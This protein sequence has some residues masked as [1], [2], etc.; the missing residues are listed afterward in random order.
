MDPNR[1][2]ALPA[3]LGEHLGYEKHA[4]EKSAIQGQA[5]TFECNFLFDH[6]LYSYSKLRLLLNGCNNG[7]KTC[8][9]MFNLRRY[10]AHSQICFWV[11]MF[12]CGKPSPI[13]S[14]QLR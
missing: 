7:V 6:F 12:H 1:L 4:P 9:K 5:I 13:L 11:E 3:E 8:G 2:K 10:Q 14:E